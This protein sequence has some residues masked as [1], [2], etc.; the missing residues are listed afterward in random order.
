MGRILDRAPHGAC[1]HVDDVSV[2]G[3]AVCQAGAEFSPLFN[4]QDPRPASRDIGKAFDHPIE[5]QYAASTCS[6]YGYG[7]FHCL[8]S[9]RR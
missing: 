9:L 6:D 7:L 3:C 8:L 1:P 2:Q 4:E 5:D